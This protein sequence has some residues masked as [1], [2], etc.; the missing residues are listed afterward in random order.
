MTRRQ[1]R[2]PPKWHERKRGTVIRFDPVHGGAFK[3]DVS[4][5]EYFLSR[6][7]LW[8]GTESPQAGDRIEY[9]VRP[10]GYAVG[11]KVIERA[12]T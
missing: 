9:S 5:T 10:E 12:K 3:A 8:P 6:D 11:I 4:G 1:V 2:S 7:E